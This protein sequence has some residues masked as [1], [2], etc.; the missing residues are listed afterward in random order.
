MHKWYD[1]TVHEKLTHLLTILQGQA[2][3]ILQS[4]PYKDITGVLRDN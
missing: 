1:W 3:N 4:D 2:T